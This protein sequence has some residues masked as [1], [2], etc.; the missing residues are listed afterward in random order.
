MFSYTGLTKN[1]SETMASKYHIYM[2]PN[3]RISIPGC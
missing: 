3:G 2:L 1:Q